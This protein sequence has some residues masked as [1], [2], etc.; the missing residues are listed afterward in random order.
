M[1]PHEARAKRDKRKRRRM[2]QIALAP[3][4]CA[5]CGY[6]RNLTIDHI[7]P[8]SKGGTDHPRNLQ[9]LCRRCNE[10]KADK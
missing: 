5:Y 10:R 7:I 8:K 4:K 6:T 1:K 3:G 9:C 2:K